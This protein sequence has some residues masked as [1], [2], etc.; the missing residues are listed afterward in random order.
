MKKKSL[1]SNKEHVERSIMRPMA[2]AIVE[3]L[4]IRKGCV[5]SYVSSV[6]LNKDGKC[7]T[8][9]VFVYEEK[10]ERETITFFYS[11]EVN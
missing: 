7:D 3:K 5:D 8:H 1:H 4:A 10:E 9:A 6:E 11:C 2:E